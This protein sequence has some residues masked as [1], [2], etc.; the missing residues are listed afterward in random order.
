MSTYRGRGR[1]RG[2]GGLAPESVVGHLFVNATTAMTASVEVPPPTKVSSSLHS[3]PH[4]APFLSNEEKQT[5]LRS[6]F[7]KMSPSSPTVA[8]YASG[9]SSAS[10]MEPDGHDSHSSS[11]QFERTQALI[12]ANLSSDNECLICIQAIDLTHPVF[13]CVSCFSIFHLSCINTW[14][15]NCEKNTQLKQLKDQFPDLDIPWYCPNCRH[16]YSSGAGSIP[17][18]YF[19][20]CGK[21]EDPEVNRWVAPHSCGM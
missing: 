2:R 20:F 3:E 5:I 13:S 7:A 17:S 1:G 21:T 16:G 11:V 18:V 4:P 6:I 19:C 10:S 12:E 8:S 15:S 14:A 9:G